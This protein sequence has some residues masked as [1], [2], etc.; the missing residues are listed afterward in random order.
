MRWFSAV[1]AGFLLCAM[2]YEMFSY[3]ATPPLHQGTVAFSISPPVG[4]SQESS[5]EQMSDMTIRE[6]G[7]Y[8]SRLWKERKEM[9]RKREDF[10]NK[11]IDRNH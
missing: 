11:L 4:L 5:L 8:L 3:S 7:M 1:A 9:Q 10:I 6:K 2:M